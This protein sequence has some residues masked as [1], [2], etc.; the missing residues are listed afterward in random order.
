MN[1]LYLFLLAP[2]EAVRIDARKQ[3]MGDEHEVTNYAR[4]TSHFSVGNIQLDL[5][6]DI[7]L[8]IRAHPIAF[9]KL[10]CMLAINRIIKIKT[11]PV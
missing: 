7:F 4:L 11:Y 6:R 5:N 9:Y 10:F 2:L 1:S 8:I 3:Q